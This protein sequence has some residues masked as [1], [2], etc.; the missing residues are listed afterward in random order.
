LRKQE[1]WKTDTFMS[2]I[3]VIALYEQL[4]KTPLKGYHTWFED[5]LQ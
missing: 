1:D 2:K 5:L 4:S 3:Q